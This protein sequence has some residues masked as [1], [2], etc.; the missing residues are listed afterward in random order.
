MLPIY[1]KKK[2]IKG[3][4]VSEGEGGW[5]FNPSSTRFTWHSGSFSSEN[6]LKIDL[7]QFRTFVST[8]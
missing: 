2:R 7:G 1:V 3:S 4:L 6:L 5:P 8:L